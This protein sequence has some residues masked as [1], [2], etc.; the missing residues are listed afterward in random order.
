MRKFVVLVA[1]VASTSLSSF[2]LCPT[3]EQEAAYKY[4]EATRTGEDV[5][6]MLS[7]RRDNYDYYNGY[8]NGY[9]NDY[10][11]SSSDYQLSSDK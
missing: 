1:V 3:D 2:T 9:Y 10:E 8:Y 7:Q 4:I 5:K 11:Y 6:I